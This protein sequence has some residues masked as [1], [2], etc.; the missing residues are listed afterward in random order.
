MILKHKETQHITAT[1]RKA[2]K[3]MFDQGVVEAH[4]KRKYYEV[5]KG[6]FS[7][8]EFTIRITELCEKDSRGIN[9]SRSVTL[10]I[11]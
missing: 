6:C 8:R 9:K 1:E 7:A 5:I 2:I 3:H 4:T 11:P 10:I